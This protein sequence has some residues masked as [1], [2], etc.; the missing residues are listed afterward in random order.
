MMRGV[1]TLLIVMAILLAAWAA[2]T[3]MDRY[4]PRTG[5]WPRL[6]AVLLLA[7]AVGGVALRILGG[8]EAPVRRPWDVGEY[9]GCG[10]DSQRAFQLFGIRAG[11]HPAKQGEDR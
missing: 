7:F 8:A 10:I 4:R 2:E 9:E 11:R 6:L 1:L 5:A 3:L